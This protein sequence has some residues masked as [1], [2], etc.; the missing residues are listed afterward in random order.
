MGKSI[1]REVPQT[2][3]RR[4]RGRSRRG[5]GQLEQLAS[6]AGT[7]ILEVVKDAVRKEASVYGAAQA[8]S[9][10]PNTVSYHLRKAGLWFRPITTIEFY[11]V[12]EVVIA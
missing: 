3:V 5:F 9:V 1:T 6:E 10:S 7:T 12:E 4:G 2:Q 8:L 11:P